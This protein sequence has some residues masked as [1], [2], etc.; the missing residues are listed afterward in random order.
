MCHGFKKSYYAARVMR[1]LLFS[2][3]LVAS[4]LAIAA[5]SLA[6]EQP[7]PPAADP[8]AT[9]IVDPNAAH[10]HAEPHDHDHAHEEPILVTITD[11]RTPKA[12]SAVTV[13]GGELKM[14]PR[15]RPADILEA[16]PG[17]FAVQHAGGGKANQYFLRGF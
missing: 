6:D 16:V 9:V 15:L 2:A 3:A 13:S 14:R 4:V 11:T 7:A 5:P 12:A 10:E 1:A 8:E 17:L